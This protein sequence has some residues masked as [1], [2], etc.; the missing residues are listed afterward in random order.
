MDYSENLFSKKHIIYLLLLLIVVVAIPLGVKLVQQQQQL[1]SQATG[2]GTITP[3][4][5]GVNCS[6]NICTTTT[7]QL[8]LDIKAMAGFTPSAT[9]GGGGQNP[10]NSPTASPAPTNPGGGGAS[11]TNS[12]APTG[13]SGGGGSG[14]VC[15]ANSQRPG[16]GRSVGPFYYA[17]TYHEDIS[18]CTAYATNCD[19]PQGYVPCGDLNNND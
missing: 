17:Q 12:P 8:Q 13:T 15:P 6:G 10:T 19:I 16:L 14:N 1:R 2:E 11:P 3:V 18:Q 7:K 4:G 9:G 5:E